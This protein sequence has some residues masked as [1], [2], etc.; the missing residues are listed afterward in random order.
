MG[1]KEFWKVEFFG[2][3]ERN[4]KKRAKRKTKMARSRH[5]S[6][7][8]TNVYIPKQSTSGNNSLNNSHNN[9]YLSNSQNLSLTWENAL[10]D[11]IPVLKL[12]Y[13]ADNGISE[14][15]KNSEKLHQLKFSSL[16]RTEYNRRCQKER[17]VSNSVSEVHEVYA[18]P[19]ARRV[20]KEVAVDYIRRFIDEQNDSLEASTHI[21]NATL[22]QDQ[23]LANTSINTAA[24]SHF[25]ENSEQEFTE[26]RDKSQST[27]QER[28]EANIVKIASQAAES[29][30]S[31]EKEAQNDPESRDQ[32][33]REIL[34]SS[35][36]DPDAEVFERDNV[37]MSST[38]NKIQEEEGANEN[39]NE[40]EHENENSESSSSSSSSNSST[41][42]SSSK[43]SSKTSKI[44]QI[45]STNN[46]Q[47]EQHIADITHQ[48]LPLKPVRVST[49][50]KRQNSRRKEEQKATEAKIPVIPVTGNPSLSVMSNHMRNLSFN[51]DQSPDINQSQIT[52]PIKTTSNF[53]SHAPYHQSKNPQMV[54]KVQRTTVQRRMKGQL[55]KTFGF[56]SDKKYKEVTLDLDN[57]NLLNDSE[58]IRREFY[59]SSDDD[60]SGTEDGNNLGNSN[61]SKKSISKPFSVQ[62]KGHEKIVV[63]KQTKIQKSSFKK[64]IDEG[65]ASLDELAESANRLALTMMVKKSNKG[66]KHTVFVDPA[67]VSFASFCLI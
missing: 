30:V 5:G 27:L 33:I 39:E 12:H 34:N 62:K 59:D 67:P 42:S 52:F 32:T 65:T 26:G 23:T 10:Q 35:Q 6:T 38:L 56:V 46:T 47:L 18:P 50:V 16:A 14:F 28:L 15:L 44:T 2:I 45:E 41:S 7:T 31:S 1:T 25:G 64:E 51:Q 60:D 13:K 37:P 48:P 66:K 58:Q 22:D 57:P 17:S 24:T 61:G 21:A 11:I 29:V 40:N 55:S 49:I 43:S 53:S 36:E 20:A 54:K 3:C 19:R 63:D 4:F 9:I 8:S